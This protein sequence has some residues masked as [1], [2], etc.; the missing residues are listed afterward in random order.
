MKKIL[1]SNQNV[2][3]GHILNKW[4]FLK[5]F[6]NKY[7]NNNIKLYKTYLQKDLDFLKIIKNFSIPE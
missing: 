1:H 2:V 3:V 5:L 6:Y 4:H 7:R